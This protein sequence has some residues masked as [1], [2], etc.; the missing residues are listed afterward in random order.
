MLC[1]TIMAS[2]FCTKNAIGKACNNGLDVIEAHCQLVSLISTLELD[3]WIKEFD[4]KND[5]YL[6]TKRLVCT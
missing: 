6:C 1:I 5:K 4:W 3:K 2:L